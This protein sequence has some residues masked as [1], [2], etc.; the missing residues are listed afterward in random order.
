VCIYQCIE[1]I[2]RTLSNSLIYNTFFML[3]THV[4][5]SVIFLIQLVDT[6]MIILYSKP[7]F[8]ARYL[9]D[10]NLIKQIHDVHSILELTNELTLP[11]SKRFRWYKKNK[12][13]LTAFLQA[14]CKEFTHRFRARHHLA[15]KPYKKI[16]SMPPRDHYTGITFQQYLMQCRIDYHSRRHLHRYKWTNRKR[17]SFAHGK[18]SGRKHIIGPH[19][20]N[21]GLPAE[22]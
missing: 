6:Q 8:A 7:R 4:L 10:R 17:P 19:I 16:K 20:P 21:R 13:W 9:D 22:D 3:L 18:L 5:Y 15:P 2:H 11:K 14:M 1:N 12:L